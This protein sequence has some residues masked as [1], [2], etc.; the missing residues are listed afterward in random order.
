MAKTQSIENRNYE[1]HTLGWK[2]FQDLCHTVLR[3]IF[4]QQVQVYSPS[5]DE[6]RDGYF[7]GKFSIN[8]EIQLNGA[9][10][11]QCKFS[12]DPKKYIRLTSLKDEY[13]KAEELAKNGRCS[14]YILMTNFPVS[15]AMSRKIEDEFKT[16]PQI[17]NVLTFGYEWITSQINESSKLRMLVP[18]VYGLGDL[19]YIKEEES[20]KKA[21][22][23]LDSMKDD[24]SKFVITEAYRKSAKVLSEKKVLILIG[25]PA[26][27]KS[28]IAASLTLAAMDKWGIIPHRINRAEDF[29]AKW[30]TDDPRQIFWIDDVF[31]SNSYQKEE[32]YKWNKLLKDFK[33]ALE[34]GARF[35]F[36]SRD[37]IFRSATNDLKVSDFPIFN[38]SQIT[39]Y[40]EEISLEEKRHILYN[41][42]KYGNQSLEFKSEIKPF[43]EY[44]ASHEKFSPET[45]RRLGNTCYT[46]HLEL[47]IDCLEDYIVKQ[48]EFLKQTL[49]ELDNDSFAAVALIFMSDSKLE[50][51]IDISKDQIKLIKKLGSSESMASQAINNLKDSFTRLEKNENGNFW[52]F[53]HPTLGDAL[54]EI[55]KENPEL[56]EIYLT[57]VK[58][59]NLIKEISCGVNIEGVEINVPTKLYTSIFTR[60]DELPLHDDQWKFRSNLANFLATRC[61][62]KFIQQYLSQ[63]TELY[64]A[65]NECGHIRYSGYGSLLQKLYQAN[66]LPE[67]I[68]KNTIGKLVGDV[69]EKYERDFFDMES[70]IPKTI[71]EQTIS[72]IKQKVLPNLSSHIESIYYD[73]QREDQPD[74]HFY[75]INSY[76]ESIEEHLDCDDDSDEHKLIGTYYDEISSYLNSLHEQHQEYLAEQEEEN[77]DS[78]E[79]VIASDTAEEI[80]ESTRSIFSDIDT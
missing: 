55:I 73:Y 72:T 23:V 66:Q 74:D 70:I 57:G 19:S 75:H 46:K 45:A 42:L 26:S 15:G 44:I 50:S 21:L 3:D 64:E 24:L 12:K 29:E 37:Y 39:I 34:R 63:R 53:K 28:T 65:L 47:N 9:T 78:E 52:T 35:I 27:G 40:L 56:L 71:F 25:E 18:R 58:A 76:I 67:Y 62:N 60:L 5:N 11:I 33:A 80:S 77:S 13:K 22:A 16:I 17:K 6:G 79:M 38:D 1:L 20:R 68:H 49:R 14:N 41:H 48:K 59:S 51:P 10:T 61:S 31:G 69:I 32:V 4:G 2:S 43:L 30:N 36:T 7:T 8:N 54:S